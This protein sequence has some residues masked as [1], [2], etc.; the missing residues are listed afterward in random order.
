M[1]ARVWILTA[2]L[3]AGAASTAAAQGGA[4][5]CVFRIVHVGRQGNVEVIGADTNYFA[6]GDVRLRCDNTPV[7]M[8]SDSVAAYAGRVVQFIRDVQYRDSTITMDTEFGTYTRAQEKWEARGKVVTRNLETGSVLWGPSLDYFRAMP[9]IRDTLEMYAVGRPRIE[10]VTTDSA[11]VRQEPYII[12]ADRVR[13]RGNDRIWAGGNVTI[14]RSDFAA[15]G[16]SLR[17]DTG[18]GSDGT[19]L[20]K[21]PELR[22]LGTD[23]FT[24]SGRRIDLQLADKQL[25]YVVAKG[26]AQAVNAGWTLNADTIALDIED[27]ALQQT[28]A[29]GDSIRPHAVSADQEIRADSLALDTPDRQLTEVRAFGSAWL[30]GATDS[31]ADERDWMSGD[32]VIARFAQVDSAG[33]ARTALT[34]IEALGDARSYHLVAAQQPGQRPSINYA[35]GAAIVVT[36]AA[37]PEDR[38]DR[39][40][41]RGQVDGIQLDPRAVTEP[42]PID[43]A[44]PRQARRAQ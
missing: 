41:V 1:I 26:G 22:G 17:L 15:R 28:L 38:V 31:V 35:R 11:G 27:R 2:L 24:L 18:A 7:T 10:Y 21:A 4:D 16:D 23:S 32:T 40:D 37:G 13:F 25:T 19:L 42:A 3:L 9:G 29:W 33:T 5:R 30:A 36:M 6:G 43:S 20:G 39:V 14:D 34:R 44:A 8:R 12:V